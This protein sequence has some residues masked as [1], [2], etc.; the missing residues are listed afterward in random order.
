MPNV[1][2]AQIKGL[3]WW[4]LDFKVIGEE[5]QPLL[6]IDNFFPTPSLLQDEASQLD[7][8]DIAP[9]YPGDRAPVQTNYL[10]ILMEGLSD[11][12]VKL[13]DFKS[14]A[15]IQECFYSRLTTPPS[16]LNMIQRLPHV[17]GGDDGKVAILHYLCGPEFG[18][19][20]FYRQKATGFETVGNEKFEDYK[21]AIH[22][23][24]N[25]LGEPNASYFYDSDGRFE[26]IGEVRAKYNRAVIYFSKNLHSV[27][28]G[29]TPLPPK[30]G[31]KIDIPTSRLTINTFINPAT[32]PSG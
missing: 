18:G 7:F 2:N 27:N 21:N 29:E 4:Q 11:P 24:H 1:T 23:A 9:Y 22:D 8:K 6:I 20:A 16:E 10:S 19:T 3:P 31:T 12:L 14:G 26:K 5:K 28:P 13:F 25:T 30:S 32:P 17:D 15:S